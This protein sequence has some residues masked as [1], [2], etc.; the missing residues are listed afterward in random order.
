MSQ[1]PQTSLDKL[2]ERLGITGGQPASRRRA[3]PVAEKKVELSQKYVSISRQTIQGQQCF[4]C[5]DCSTL[6]NGPDS[7]YYEAWERLVV[8]SE[9][10]SPQMWRKLCRSCGVKHQNP[11]IKISP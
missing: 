7:S 5:F 6:V 2:A 4:P 11:T 9:G 10:S 8:P 1:K 3:V